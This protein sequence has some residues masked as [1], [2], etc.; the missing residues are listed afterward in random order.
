MV[1]QVIRSDYRPP[2]SNDGPVF[3]WFRIRGSAWKDGKKTEEQSSWTFI[4]PLLGCATA[5]RMGL[6]A[7]CYKAHAVPGQPD[8]AL[9]EDNMSDFIVEAELRETS[10]RSASR[11]LRR[12]GKVP[13][14]I[15]GGDKPD[16]SIAM[17]YFPI[18]NMLDKEAFH[19]SMLEVSVK[20]S[21]GKNTVMLKDTQ[22]DPVKDTVTHLDFFRVSSDDS[23]T[24]DVPVI[25]INEDK[26]PGVAQGGLVDMIRHS[27]E[28]TSRAD[29]I[30]SRIEVNCAGLEIGDTVHIE[31][32]TLPEGAV[33]HHEVNFTVLNVSAQKTAATDEDEAED[34]GTDT[35]GTATEA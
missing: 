28:V 31:D 12:A 9:L 14:I 2:L 6:D 20:G 35:E 34:T 32:I 24:V 7:R 3:L 18:A 19:T 21:R 10:G 13:G 1:A 25:A 30:P 26:S 15:Y 5:R 29:S 27:L 23:I 22:W 17:E 33:V 8:G 4:Y 16:L 11:R